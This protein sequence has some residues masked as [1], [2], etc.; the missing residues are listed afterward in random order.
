M[1]K[2]TMYNAA[3]GQM[4]IDDTPQRRAWAK[5]KGY[6]YDSPPSKSAAPAPKPKPKTDPE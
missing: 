1:N 3:G 4:E 6:E 5:G 2:V